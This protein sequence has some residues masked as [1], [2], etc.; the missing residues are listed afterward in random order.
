MVV[1]ERRFEQL[2]N[3]MQPVSRQ[4]VPNIP[5]CSILLPG[6]NLLVL[7]DDAQVI[8]QPPADVEEISLFE[9]HRQIQAQ[10]VTERLR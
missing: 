10:K 9:I 2:W 5:C 7:C 4:V 1:T 3:K 8:A 6:M